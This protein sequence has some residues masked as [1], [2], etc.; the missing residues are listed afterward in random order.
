MKIKLS[1]SGKSG[2]STTLNDQVCNWMTSNYISA[3]QSSIKGGRL[4]LAASYWSGDMNWLDG[5]SSGS[6][7]PTSSTIT[8]KDF[9][10]IS[11]ITAANAEDISTNNDLPFVQSP[12]FI[13]IMCA[14]GLLLLV[15]L[16]AFIIIKR[17]NSLTQE[18]V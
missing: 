8:F 17:K 2:L 11:G 7:C 16:I 1:Q 10:I 15:G 9:Q 14:I 12:V 13:G 6:T 3:L 4:A 5:C 18:I